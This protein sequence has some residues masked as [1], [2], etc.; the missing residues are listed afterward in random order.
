MWIEMQKNDAFDV[1]TGEMHEHLICQEVQDDC[2]DGVVNN[3][4]SRKE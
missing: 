2:G 1:E 4:V 3:M